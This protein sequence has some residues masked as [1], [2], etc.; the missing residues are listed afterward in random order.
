MTIDSVILEHSG[1]SQ[2]IVKLNEEGSLLWAKKIPLSVNSLVVDASE[3]IYISGGFIM[4]S[5]TIDGVTLTYQNHTHFI[6]RCYV[7]KLDNEGT[8]IWAK[9]GQANTDLTNVSYS[10]AVAVDADG[11]VYMG[12]FF[13]TP[14]LVFDEIVL[15]KSNTHLNSNNMFIVKYTSDGQALWAKSAG[16][17]YENVTSIQTIITDAQHNVYA[18]GFFSNTVSF[19][20]IELQTLTGGSK[21]FTVK[22]DNAG[23]ELWVRRPISPDG[24]NC[25]QSSGMDS[26]GNLYVAGTTST[27]LV[28]HGGIMLDVEEEGGFFVA[29]YNP[30]GN[31]VWAKASGGVD[32]NADVAITCF[33]DETVYI[34]G[35]FSEPSLHFDATE[36]IKTSGNHDRFIAK[37]H[38][39]DALSATAFDHTSLVVYPNPVQNVIHLANTHGNSEY[40]VTDISGKIILKGQ[41]ASGNEIAVDDLASGIYI[42]QL[43]SEGK[44]SAT[45]IVKL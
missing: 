3:Q 28:F 2:F 30:D 18:S 29:R 39:E 33:D 13:S 43:S 32:A 27:D 24:F 25:I 16:S 19:G 34:A 31:A 5:V 12:G 4:P 41:L 7:A 10:N 1:G 36:L 26:E 8:C 14:T 9:A 11:S 17:V 44:T 42:L 20:A 21:I 6:S 35:T 22:Y 15:T 37:L 40:T 23:N 38:H 45:K